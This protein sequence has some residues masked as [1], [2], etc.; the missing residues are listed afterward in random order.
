MFNHKK[1][2]QIA[3][4]P[5]E[6][7]TVMQD[8]DDE[9]AGNLNNDLNSGGRE[10]PQMVGDLA[11]QQKEVALDSQAMESWNRVMAE[12]QKM[13][14]DGVDVLQRLSSMPEFVDLQNRINATSQDALQQKQRELGIEGNVNALGFA[15]DLQLTERRILDRARS[16]FEREKNLHDLQSVPQGL[17]RTSQ[18]QSFPVKNAGDLAA[19]FMDRILSDQYEIYATAIN[20]ILFN[21]KGEI[22]EQEVKSALKDLHEMDPNTQQ[23]EA[24]HL[25][26]RLY[27]ML[28]AKLKASE[29]EQG[30]L[31]ANNDSNKLVKHSLS[32][33]V[34]NNVKTAADQFGQHYL[35]YGPTEKRICPKMAGKNM[36]DVVSEYICRHYCLDGIVIDDNKTICGEALWR[37]NSMD[38]FSRE[39]VNKDGEIVGGYLNKRFEINRNVPEETKMRLKPG[40]TRKPR[41]PEWGNLESRMQ[42]MRNKDADKRDYRPDANTGEPFKW[43]TDVDQNNVQVSQSERDRREEAMGHQI[44]QYTNK[45][46]LENNPKSAEAGFN[47]KKFAS[48]Q[49]KNDQPA[50][51]EKSGQIDSD[52]LKDHIPPHKT[53]TSKRGLTLVPND[54]SPCQFCGN[55][56]HYENQ[57]RIESICSKCGSQFWDRRK[58]QSP[59]DEGS[60]RL[61]FNLRKFQSEKY[62]QFNDDM[63]TDEHGRREFS[64]DQ[65]DMEFSKPDDQ[66][67]MQDHAEEWYMEQGNIVP[68]RGTPEWDQM[69]LEWHQYAFQDF[70][71]ADPTNDGPDLP[72]GYK[73]FPDEQ[74]VDEGPQDYPWRRDEYLPPGPRAFNLT[75]NTKTAQAIHCGKCHDCGNKLNRNQDGEEW[76]EQCS[77]YRRYRSHGWAQGTADPQSDSCPTINE[78]SMDMP[79]PLRPAAGFN[80]RHFKLAQMPGDGTSWKDAIATWERQNLDQVGNYIGED[81][82][83]LGFSYRPG[84]WVPVTSRYSAMVEHQVAKKRQRFRQDM[85]NLNPNKNRRVAQGAN[86]PVP[87]D[88]RPIEPQ[89]QKI[90]SKPMTIPDDGFADGG[91]PYT[92]EEMALIDKEEQKELAERL[93]HWHGGSGSFLYRL[94]SS[95]YAGHDVPEDV[96]KGAYRELQNIVDKKVNYPEAVTPEDIAEIKGM[97]QHLHK[98]LNLPSPGS[99]PPDNSIISKPMVQAQMTGPR[100]PVGPGNPQSDDLGLSP[101]YS[102]EDEIEQRDGYA[103]RDPH[104]NVDE[105]VSLCMNVNSKEEMISIINSSIKSPENRDMN[106][107]DWDDVI[108]A[109][110]DELASTGQYI[111]ASSE[112]VDYVNIKNNEQQMDQSD[113]DADNAAENAWLTHSE[114]PDFTDRDLWPNAGFNLKNFKEAK[115]NKRIAHQPETYKKAD[116][117]PTPLLKKKDITLQHPQLFNHNILS[118]FKNDM[119]D[120]H[121]F[122]ES[123]QPNELSIIIKTPNAETV[124]QI[125][126]LVDADVDDS[127]KALEIEN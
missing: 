87:A 123:L 64:L 42:A 79:P 109:V 126:Q 124:M 33:Q 31:M 30:L 34:L 5:T 10:T 59:Q 56:S 46:E 81:L 122:L 51:N 8:A 106:S 6:L 102:Y 48:V 114:R 29:Q 103:P 28:P 115:K 13:N 15:S 78:G 76:C 112:I 19:K 127:A 24:A 111:D 98:F 75:K 125:K 118:I 120:L 84:Q 105:I 49:K 45:D 18:V 80:L 2:S 23:A 32:D 61:G 50:V 43:C 65:P 101:D 35:L 108:N 89:E 71:G 72:A 119:D 52:W 12:I 95:W 77:S 17:G 55:H 99:Y 11:E 38:K 21:V 86:I 20:E 63:H 70:G 1:H 41:P 57:D 39:Y 40:E 94:G 37:A 4:V 14:T 9:V 91:E 7:A 117:V 107:H 62:A 47:L 3:T 73:D 25:F 121:D 26:G 82:S 74:Y 68:M 96:I 44:V 66:K 90:R 100:G 113:Y 97:Q 116:I 58:L 27:E 93:L 53:E 67:T 88:G 110:N 83:E 92:D 85:P 22:Q 60:Q 104:P 69:Y 16:I 36:G 54:D